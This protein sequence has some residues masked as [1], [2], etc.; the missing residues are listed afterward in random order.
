MQDHDLGRGGLLRRAVRRRVRHLRLGRLIATGAI[1]LLLGYGG[2]APA[3]AAD[4]QPYKFGIAKTGNAAL[5][6]ALKQSAYLETL[7]KS[8]PVDPFA[9]V[10]RANEDVSRLQTTMQSFGY[11]QARVNILIA[12]RPLSDPGLLV[13]LDQVPKGQSVYVYADIDPGTLYRLRRI[14]IDGAVPKD[15]VSKMK[16]EQ[17]QPAV[18]ADVVAGA[19]RLVTALQEEGY[20]L[21]KVDSPVAF[22]DDNA[23][24]L[25]LTFKVDMGP[26]TDIGAI[27]ISGL[28]DVDEDVVRRAISV[29]T[30]DLYR[31]SKIEDARN[32]LL[33]LGV[34]S[35]VEV[36]AADR[37][38][39]QGRV[40]INYDVSERPGHAVSF[41]AAYSTDLGFSGGVTW[42][43]RNLFGGA[44]QLNL[45]A[46]INGVGGTASSTLGYNATAQFIKPQFLAHDQALEFDLGGIKQKLDAYD[47]TAETVAALLRRKFSTLW[48]GSVGL[49]VE[50]DDITQEKVART[51]QLVSVPFSVNYDSTELSGLLQDPTHGARAAVSLTPTQS[52]GH[53]S[54][55]FLAMQVGGAA[56]FD[57][58]DFG[59]EKPTE[60]VFATRATIAS[61]VGA[62]QFDLP[63]DRRLYAGGSATVRGYRFQS[64]GPLFPDQKP[65]GGTAMDA[66]TI[67]FRQHL[68]GDFAAAAFIDAGQDSATGVPFSGPLRVGAGAGVRYYTPVGPVRVDFALPLT[69]IRASDAF[70]IYIGLGQAF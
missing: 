59:I 68:F 22:A 70:E 61:I 45:S 25:D 38:D 55:P 24:A 9:L 20:A 11:Y 33:S 66:G 31:P 64:I 16:L 44:E 21:A 15:A 51:Y 69:R 29:H 37:L 40:P 50:Q 65:I 19:T 63:P 53:R 18:A 13:W 41:T 35:G 67:E 48:S 6:A 4:P 8:A 47:Q 43:D 57:L 52:F 14:S 5:D 54:S 34:F 62:G 36:H 39:P 7:K 28:H 2:C 1:A 23:H 10:A 58:A 32:S 17:G 30:G 49:S 60:G 26:K 42:S 56:Y 46:A 3:R 12:R 27:T